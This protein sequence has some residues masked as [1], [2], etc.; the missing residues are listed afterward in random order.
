MVIEPNIETS[1]AELRKTPRTHDLTPKVWGRDYA[2][3]EILQGGL[4]I[5][6]TAWCSQPIEVG[7]YVLIR[8]AG[9]STR[10]QV[11]RVVR[12]HDPGDQYFIQAQFAPRPAPEN[13]LIVL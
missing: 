6:M 5:N 13:S 3:T 12:P 11:E 8:N 4:R 10:Y 2:T 7:D 9:G 1:Q